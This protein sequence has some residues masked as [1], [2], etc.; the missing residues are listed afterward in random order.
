[1]TTEETA[2][3]EVGAGDGAACIPMFEEERRLG[4]KELMEVYNSP[5]TEIVQTERRVYRNCTIHRIPS[6]YI[7][8]NL[9]KYKNIWK[10]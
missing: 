4:E 8:R 6:F 1:M 5:Y 10:L 9:V 3:V 7:V 2:E